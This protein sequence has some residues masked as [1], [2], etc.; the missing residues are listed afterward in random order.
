MADQETALTALARAYRYHES[1]TK[2]T[3]TSRDAIEAHA[4]A[5]SEIAESIISL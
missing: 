5:A 2:A 3:W 4:D 1:S